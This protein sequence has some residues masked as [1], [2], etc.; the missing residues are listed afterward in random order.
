MYIS[1]GEVSERLFP[2][3]TVVRMVFS[4]QSKGDTETESPKAETKRALTSRS[5][6]KD[7]AMEKLNLAAGGYR[8]VWEPLDES[9]RVK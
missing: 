7:T 1:Q 9:I 4:R 8:K 3:L 6:D 2:Y 5:N